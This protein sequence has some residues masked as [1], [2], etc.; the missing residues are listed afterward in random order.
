MCVFVYLRIFRPLALHCEYGL[1]QNSCAVTMV[2]MF[3]VFWSSILNISLKILEKYCRESSLLYDRDLTSG[4]L[5]CVF[6][7]DYC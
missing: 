7:S 5:I 6:I 2:Q 4:R 1:K 3:L